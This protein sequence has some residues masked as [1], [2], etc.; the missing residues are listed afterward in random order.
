MKEQNISPDKTSPLKKH[1]MIGLGF[2]LA[3]YVV[4]AFL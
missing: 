2:G 4:A 3:T 1:F